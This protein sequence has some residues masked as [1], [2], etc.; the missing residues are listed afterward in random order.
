MG[1]SHIPLVLRSQAAGPQPEL[2]ASRYLEDV[3]DQ[4]VGE[5][6]HLHLEQIVLVG[7]LDRQSTLNSSLMV[8]LYEATGSDFL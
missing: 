6:S 3:L 2:Q 4:V 7:D 8:S 5:G 1:L